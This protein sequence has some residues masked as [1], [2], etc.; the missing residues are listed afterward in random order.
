M[1]ERDQS[2]NPL[3]V[4]DY[5][6]KQKLVIEIASSMSTKQAIAFNSF[7]LMRGSSILLFLLIGYFIGYH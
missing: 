1:E 3:F 6:L 4:N 7:R 2:I 5:V